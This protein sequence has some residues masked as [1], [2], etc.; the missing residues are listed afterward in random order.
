MKPERRGLILVVAVLLL[1][2]VLG[3][4]YGPNVAA[5]SNNADDYQTSVRD[6][7]HALDV[8][9]ANY[10]EPVDVD[11]SGL[12]RSDSGHAAGARSAL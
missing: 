12:C 8:V 1:S 2:A 7:T 11:K 10:A 4:L 3:G 6:F 5:T 9:Q